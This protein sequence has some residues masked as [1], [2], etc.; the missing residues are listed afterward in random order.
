MEFR[1]IETGKIKELVVR[2]KNNIEWT[3]DLLGNA[4]SLHYNEELEVHELTQND[5]NWW[6]EYITN[7]KKDKEEIEELA[8]ELNIDE[9]EIWERIQEQMFRA[10]DMEDEHHLIQKVIEE[11]R[12]L[13]KE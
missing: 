5:F 4:G 13:F 11:F 1:I 8:E 3:N 9:T 12:D 2:D 10:N 7:Y 6:A